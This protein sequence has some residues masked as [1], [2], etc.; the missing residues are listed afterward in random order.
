MRG[1]DGGW[2]GMDGEGGHGLR[3]HSASLRATRLPG[4]TGQ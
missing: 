1:G 3:A 4:M 2:E